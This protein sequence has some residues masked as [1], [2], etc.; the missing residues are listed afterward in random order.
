MLHGGLLLWSNEALLFSYKHSFT[1]FFFFFQFPFLRLYFQAWVNF[2]RL[3]F[4]I[5]LFD[6]LKQGLL[7]FCMNEDISISFTVIYGSSFFNEEIETLRETSG[8]LGQNL[9]SFQYCLIP[10]PISQNP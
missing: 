2:F 7:G 10:P 6:F 1:P 5:L 9:D 8:K 4:S 3:S